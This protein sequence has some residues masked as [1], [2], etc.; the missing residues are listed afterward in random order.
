[1]KYHGNDSLDAALIELARMI[2]LLIISG[3]ILVAGAGVALGSFPLPPGSC[4][5]VV[6]A[7]IFGG[8]ITGFIAYCAG[9]ANRLPSRGA[10][11][12]VVVLTAASLLFLISNVVHIR[13]NSIVQILK[14]DVGLGFCCGGIGGMVGWLLQPADFESRRRQSRP[15]RMLPKGDEGIEILE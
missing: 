10:F 1:M 11:W 5:L 14:F 15:F 9:A 4:G 12:G 2:V 3:P 8:G 7:P 6:F 13:W